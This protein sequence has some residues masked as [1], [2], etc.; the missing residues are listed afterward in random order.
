MNRRASIIAGI[1]CL[2]S[3]AASLAAESLPK[4]LR[5]FGRWD[6]RKPDR[7]VT[8]NSA[9]YVRARFD[10]TGV[11]AT[12]DLSLNKPPVP[13]IAW[14]IDDGEWQ[15]AEAA[16][17]VTLAEKLPAGPHALWLMARGMDEHQARW[18][19]PLVASL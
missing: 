17:R 16:P 7:A 18:T 9:S 8:V 5:F 10:G 13:T 3:S 14:R 12:F 11:A 1:L 4:Q 15:E 2:V 19:P 6:L